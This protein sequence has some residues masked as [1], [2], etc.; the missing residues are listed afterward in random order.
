[1]SAGRLRERVEGAP[2]CKS[3]QAPCGSRDGRRASTTS[4]FRCGRNGRPVTRRL[5][6]FAS[7]N[8]SAR[9]LVWSEYV[10]R[11][12][13]TV[14]MLLIWRKAAQDKWRAVG[15]FLRRRWGSTAILRMPACRSGGEEAIVWRA[16]LALP[17]TPRSWLLPPHARC[18]F[19]LDRRTRRQAPTRA[20]LSRR[21]ASIAHRL[22]QVITS[23]KR[24]R[25]ALTSFLRRPRTS[26]RRCR[27]SPTT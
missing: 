3:A 8:R 15:E 19:H 16:S 13:S 12:K 20:A 22:L 26:R 25:G 24:A 11:R 10:S 21:A 9:R 27:T 14:S 4:V 18:P 5:T 23:R 6:S 17:F 1:M 2:A 7:R